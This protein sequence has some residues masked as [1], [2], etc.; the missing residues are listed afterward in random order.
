MSA[1]LSALRGAGRQHLTASTV[2]ARQAITGS[3]VL[4]LHDYNK[5]LR[6]KVPNGHFFESAPFG[7]GGHTWKVVCYPNGSDREHDGY[8]SLFLKT[9]R[10]H[11]DPFIFDATTARLQASVLDR[12]G[13]PWRTQTA[14]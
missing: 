11:D 7:A 12:D 10:P 14:E 5:V 8:T 9:L 13:K 6:K 4:R 2:A 3:H 1:L